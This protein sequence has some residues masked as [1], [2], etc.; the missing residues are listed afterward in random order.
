MGKGRWD[1]PAP[2][3]RIDGFKDSRF[4]NVVCGSG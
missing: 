2:Q 4:D 3:A 1:I